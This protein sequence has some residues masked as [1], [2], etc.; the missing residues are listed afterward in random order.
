MIH[1][2]GWRIE[3]DPNGEV[4]FFDPEGNPHG[5]TRPR[6]IP[7]PLPTRIGNE[8]TRIRE[9]AFALSPG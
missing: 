9:R 4:T 2:G 3:G 6:A 7:P 8:I 1:E 5:T